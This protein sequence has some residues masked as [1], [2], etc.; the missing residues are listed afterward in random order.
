MLAGFSVLA[1]VVLPPRNIDAFC[2]YQCKC[3]L[4]A[5]CWVR[6]LATSLVLRCVQLCTLSSHA[7]SAVATST[8]RVV[9][10]VYHRLMIS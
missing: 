3:S 1:R 9:Y 6:L 2:Q 4:L 10:L 8:A 5:S 7:T